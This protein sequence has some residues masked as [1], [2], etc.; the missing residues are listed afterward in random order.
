ME[1]TLKIISRYVK[2]KKNIRIVSTVYLCSF[3]GVV[4]QCF[5]ESINIPK[6]WLG[7]LAYVLREGLSPKC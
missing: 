1:L 7:Y 6:E 4:E 5:P 3:L 2:G